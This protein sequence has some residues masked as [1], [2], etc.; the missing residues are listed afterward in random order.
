MTALLWSLP[1]WI[2]DCFLVTS[3][4][5]GWS[6]HRLRGR[7]GRSKGFCFVDFTEPASAQAALTSMN[8]FDLMGRKIKVGQMPVATV[9]SVRA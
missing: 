4:S 9:S 6:P 5:V 1:C 8:G 3:I 7:V 2:R